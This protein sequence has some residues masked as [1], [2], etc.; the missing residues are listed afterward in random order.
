MNLF[1]RIRRESNGNC[2]AWL[3]ERS[4]GSIKALECRMYGVM[5]SDAAERLARRMADAGIDV[6]RTE[7]V[8]E[9]NEEIEAAALAKQEGMLF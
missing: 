5:S 7:A 1:L 4:S 3:I 6:E 8:Y 9:R 2:T